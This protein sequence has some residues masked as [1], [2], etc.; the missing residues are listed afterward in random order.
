MVELDGKSLL[1][2]NDESAKNFIFESSQNK[3]KK[4]SFLGCD[5]DKSYQKTVTF[6]NFTNQTLR[7]EWVE[8]QTS[9]KIKSGG[10]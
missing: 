1:S 6:Q 9:N 7:Y 3:E 4:M 5:Y 2:S 8:V 10:Y